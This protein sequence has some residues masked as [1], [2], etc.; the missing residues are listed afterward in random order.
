MM[1]SARAVS[2]LVAAAAV[3]GRAALAAAA[4]PSLRPLVTPFWLRGEVERLVAVD[5]DGD[6]LVDL[7]VAAYGRIRFEGL[8]V[9]W[10]N[11]EESIDNR[12]RIPH[13]DPEKAPEIVTIEL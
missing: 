6:G 11:K 7:A 12:F 8:T 2:L 10:A 3:L 4:D 13:F 5:L 9:R 1:R